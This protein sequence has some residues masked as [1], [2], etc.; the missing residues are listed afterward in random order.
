MRPL[1][2]A[3]RAIRIVLHILVGLVLAVAV[4]LDPTRRLDPEPLSQ[5]WS[6]HL[7]R[8]L[9]IRLMVHGQMAPGGQMIVAN[10]VSWLD[11]FAILALHPTRF[12]AKAEIRDWPIAGWLANAI[13]TFYIR[14]GKGGARP[15]LEKLEPFLAGGGCVVIFPEGTTTDGQ[16]VL[17]FHSRLFSA[18]SASGRPIQPVALRYSRDDRGRDLAPFIGEDD[19]VRHILRLL[20][21]RGLVIEMHVLPPL[22]QTQDIPRDELALDA[23]QA[24]ATALRVHAEA[25]LP[26]SPAAN[27]DWATAP[28][29]TSRS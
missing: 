23:W 13:G 4:R 12:V 20:A 29:Q 11:I 7:L 18:A 24:V 19:L 8:L 17:P 10:H 1:I 16:Q 5:W 14:R 15:L 27:E 3:F 26:E 21:A 6:R 28:A 25:T 22:T 9:G 2:A